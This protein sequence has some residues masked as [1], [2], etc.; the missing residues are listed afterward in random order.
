MLNFI[1]IPIHSVKQY[2]FFG[3]STE[4]ETFLVGELDIAAESWKGKQ[5]PCLFDVKSDTFKPSTQLYSFHFHHTIFA[6]VSSYFP[7]LYVDTNLYRSH[8]VCASLPRLTIIL[9]Q[10]FEKKKSDHFDSS[11]FKKCTLLME[12]G[13][14]SNGTRP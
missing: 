12:Y 6:S 8:C 7:S 9:C 1:P 14:S 4:H 13:P 11:V 10:R 2:Y 5:S 3:T